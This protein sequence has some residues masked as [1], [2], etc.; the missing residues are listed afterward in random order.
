MLKISL[1][2]NKI[3]IVG[4]T[5]IQS[6]ARFKL[7]MWLTLPSK[8]ASN[9][10][11]QIL[12]W[13]GCSEANWVTPGIHLAEW[14]SGWPAGTSFKTAEEVSINKEHQRRQCCLG[15]GIVSI[16]DFFDSRSSWVY[17]RIVGSSSNPRHGNTQP[18]ARCAD[19]QRCLIL[20][21]SPKIP[22]IVC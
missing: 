12:C 8:T 17:C 19:F 2:I 15:R 10:V 6:C 3:S 22:K 13:H 7:V 1:G 18:G 16:T 14:V 4:P 21:K 20:R 5:K 9:T 11:S